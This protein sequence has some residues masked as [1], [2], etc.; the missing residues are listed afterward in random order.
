MQCTHPR[1]D[2]PDLRAAHAQRQAHLH[3]GVQGMAGRARWQARDVGCGLGVAPRCQRQSTAA[4]D[5]ARGATWQRAP[6]LLPVYIE[7]AQVPATPTVPVSS[8]A[9]PIEIEWLAPSCVTPKAAPRRLPPRVPGAEAH[10]REL[11]RL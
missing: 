11:D 5:A 10:G 9:A 1:V 8:A 6:V 4:L 2:E 3:L 7:H